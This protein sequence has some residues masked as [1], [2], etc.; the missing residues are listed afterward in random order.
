MGNYWVERPQ[1]SH[2]DIQEAKTAMIRV[3][4][5]ISPEG[6]MITLKFRERAK[7]EHS[8]ALING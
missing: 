3:R 1:N 5:M 4:D 2:K 7:G 8:D 6:D